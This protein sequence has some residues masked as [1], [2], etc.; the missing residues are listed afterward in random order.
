V[1]TTKQ[2]NPSFGQL[3]RFHH[4]INP[5]KVFGTYTARMPQQTL[6]ILLNDCRSYLLGVQTGMRLRPEE[7]MIADY[8]ASHRYR[9][10]QQNISA[11][12]TS[13]CDGGMDRGCLE[14]LQVFKQRLLLLVAQVRAKLVTA[15][16][17][18]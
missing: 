10:A 4:V 18:P 1:A 12:P 9:S 6:V 8:L 13:C 16:A 5:D 11:F 14:R 7:P 17:V 15:S 3:R 2:N